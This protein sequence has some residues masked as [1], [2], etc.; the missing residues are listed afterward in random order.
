[1]AL[2]ILALLQ[3]IFLLSSLR[4]FFLLLRRPPRSTLFPYTT[5]FRSRIVRSSP[6]TRREVLR[7]SRMLLYLLS[8]AAGGCDVMLGFRFR[9][10]RVPRFAKSEPV[11]LAGRKNGQRPGAGR[12]VGHGGA[13]AWCRWCGKGYRQPA[14]CPFAA[15]S[16]A[17]MWCV[18]TKLV[19]LIPDA[20]A[21]VLSAQ[22]RRAMNGKA[23]AGAGF[24][25]NALLVHDMHASLMGAA[26]NIVHGYRAGGALAYGLAVEGDFVFVAALQAG[27]AAHFKG[28]VATAA[29]EGLVVLRVYKSEAVVVGAFLL[30]FLPKLVGFSHH[31]R[32]GQGDGGNWFYFN[33][34]AAL[35][36]LV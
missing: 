4:F 27:G 32:F 13:V 3:R 29:V 34:F 11:F 33:G 5:L 31:F 19:Q 35:H 1:M 22:D 24:H 28:D 20:T 30:D 25:L 36:R 23:D 15:Q 7:L 16:M 21:D 8:G 26:V 10:M 17:L 9:F 6:S 12:P 2:L 18:C 14:I